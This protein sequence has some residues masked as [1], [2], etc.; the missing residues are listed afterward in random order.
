MLIFK[1]TSELKKEQSKT[2]I[3]HTFTVPGNVTALEVDYSYTPKT[4]QDGEDSVKEAL[5]RYGEGNE[6]PSDFMP[7]SN[8]LTLSFD[9]P[10]GYRGA[11]HRQANTQ[12]VIIGEN[13]TPGI[14]NRK[15]KSG[16]WRVTLNAHYIGCSVNYELIIKGVEQ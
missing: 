12:K 5:A 2:N 4:V 6:S 10:E 9:D 7:V 16:K 15:I 8:L 11:C 14:F 13:S 1:T 3:S